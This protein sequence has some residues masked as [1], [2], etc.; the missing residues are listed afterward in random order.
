MGK[1]MMTVYINIFVPHLVPIGIS[2]NGCSY[3]EPANVAECSEAHQFAK[4]YQLVSGYHVLE[5]PIAALLP[6][7]TPA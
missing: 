5:M 7:V 3:S 2:C 4:S 1:I 6:F